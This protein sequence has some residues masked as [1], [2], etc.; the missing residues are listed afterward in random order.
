MSTF[1]LSILERKRSQISSMFKMYYSVKHLSQWHLHL[2]F[3]FNYCIFVVT[4][5]LK[6][7]QEGN[8]KVL[9]AIYGSVC[10]FM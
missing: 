4:I 2:D 6:L 3:F 1:V 8:W 7:K 10:C 5:I 9:L